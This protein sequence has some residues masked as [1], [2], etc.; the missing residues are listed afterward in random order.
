MLEL[1][2]KEG[3]WSLN[4]LSFELGLSHQIS[5]T[6]QSLNARFNERLVDLLRS[7]LESLLHDFLQLD[8]PLVSTDFDR[9]LLKDSTC[10]QLP[11]SLASCYPGS[12]GN[13]SAAAIRIQFEYNLLDGQITD[14]SLHPFNDQDISNAV[15]TID[16]VE[17]NDLIIRDLGYVKTGVLQQID[18]AK[19]HFISRLPALTRVY[20][21]DAKSGEVHAIDFGKLYR[22]M[23]RNKQ[24]YV[25][26]SILLGSEKLPL[27]LYIEVVPNEVYAERMRKA[28]DN[29][30]KKGRQV[31]KGK[32]ERARFNLMLTNIES[33]DF[34]A[35]G[36]RTLYRIRWQ[37][38]LVFKM[39]KSYGHLAKVKAMKVQRV[40]A[41]I[42][43]RLIWVVLCGN[44]ASSLI[45][46]ARKHDKI[47]LSF[48]KISK[49]LILR[50]DKIYAFS[51]QRAAKRTKRLEELLELIFTRCRFE[52][53]KGEVSS[54]DI[55]DL[56][57]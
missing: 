52:Q 20:E 8:A 14:L 24:L 6:K 44:I 16:K 23:R 28:Q 10:F 51:Q 35:Q 29:A 32:K 37:I 47:R 5:I 26:K 49:N 34:S 18:Q 22:S 55:Y 45:R 41:L 48:I 54:H 7:V 2:G 53:K 4:D 1:E 12:G 50:F 15:E 57:L 30:K 3:Q 25:C 46:W 9:I 38:E 43:L 40:N 42:Y 13:G 36:L 21:E 31:S 33:K 11:P 39:W 17:S 56:L 27:K 19:A